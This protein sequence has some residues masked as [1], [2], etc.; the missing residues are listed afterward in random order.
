[1][2]ISLPNIYY[3]ISFLLFPISFIV[4][5]LAFFNEPGSIFARLLSGVFLGFLS[6]LVAPFIFLISAHIIIITIEYFKDGE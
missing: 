5:F 4:G 6:G 1:M 3:K 2:N